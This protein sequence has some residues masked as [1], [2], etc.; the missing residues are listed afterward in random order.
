[1]EYDELVSKAELETRNNKIVKSAMKK[2]FH[3]RRRRVR[4]SLQ[5]LVRW[6][7]NFLG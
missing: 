7:G 2:T 6:W 5:Q 4:R 1:M 3:N